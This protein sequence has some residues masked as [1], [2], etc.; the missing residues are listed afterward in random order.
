MEGTLRAELSRDLSAIGR[1]VASKA[2]RA[3]VETQ[4]GAIRSVQEATR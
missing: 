2:E 4:I 3:V 1:Q